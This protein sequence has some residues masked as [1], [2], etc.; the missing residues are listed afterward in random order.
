[1]TLSDSDSSQLTNADEW[2][3]AVT[4]ESETTWISRL[5]SGSNPPSL[6][7]HGNTPGEVESK[8]KRLLKIRRLLRV[9]TI[10]DT[11]GAGRGRVPPTDLTV[12]DMR[13]PSI[14]QKIQQ[15]TPPSGPAPSPIALAFSESARM[16]LPALL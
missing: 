13:H 7:R 1:M 8:Q 11:G 15:S 9:V 5:Q 3:E 14:Q 6:I 4:G 12:L 16:C 2:G 10:K